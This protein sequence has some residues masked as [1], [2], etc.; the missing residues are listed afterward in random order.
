MRSELILYFLG[1]RYGFNMKKNR[2]LVMESQY[3]PTEKMARYQENRLAEV[4][5]HAY[6]H[7]PFYRHLFEEAELTPQDI[8][9][10]GDLQK[11]PIVRKSDILKSPSAFMA[12]DADKYPYMHHHTGGTTGIPCPY[13]NDRKSWALNWALKMRTFE[14]AGYRYGVDR[15][16]VM[17][18][19]SLIPGKNTGLKHRVWR[20]INNYYSMPIT[21]MTPETMDMYAREIKRQKIEFMRG[22]PTAI[23][24]F[25]EYLIGKGETIPMKSI[26]TTAEMLYPHQRER[27]R[28][29]FRCDVYNTYGCGDGMG[30]ATDCE[31]HDGMHICQEVS[32]MQI[33]NERGE[34]VD[35]G[36][37]GEIVLTSLYDFAMPFIRYAPGDR[38][39]KGVD[40]CE[41]GRTMP[42]IKT[43]I[44]RSS[45]NFKFSN[46]RVVNALSFPFEELVEEV[47]KFQI[48][49]EQ[50]DIVCLLI[51]PRDKLSDARIQQFKNL[52]AFHCGE[53]VKIE[54]KIVDDI[55]TPSSGKHRYI[56]SKVDNG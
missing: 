12:D 4:I 26:F 51:I 21:H 7:V 29:A 13:C 1:L 14:W 24:A 23:T 47:E 39:I 52:L 54:V 37:E 31:C 27:I 20:W 8:R 3:W 53:G 45:D 46:G 17:A 35:E 9:T 48:V 22:Y 44:G 36:Q 19:G 18:G 55:P 43:I 5:T 34:E 42:M 56:V 28:A 40:K 25:A 16:A 38:A 10:I 6:E 2:Q 30:Q 11:L 33:V 32:I 41:C 50:R 15:L 49:Q